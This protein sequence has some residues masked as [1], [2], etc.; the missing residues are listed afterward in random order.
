MQSINLGTVIWMSHI[1]VFGDMN[2][3]CADVGV[4]VASR[5]WLGWALLSWSS[6]KG[7]NS[8]DDV[9]L[10]TGDKVL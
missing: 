9:L 3:L 6:G 7:H 5:T 10:I 1:N 4:T 8:N 2:L